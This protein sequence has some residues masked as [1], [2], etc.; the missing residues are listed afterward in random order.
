MGQGELHRAVL[1]AGTELGVVVLL[2]SVGIRLFAD[3]RHRV[4]LKHCVLGERFKCFLTF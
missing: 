4:S 1:E 3:G 2:V